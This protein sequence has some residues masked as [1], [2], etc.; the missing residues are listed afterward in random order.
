MLTDLVRYKLAC[1]N[2]FD[3]K[4]WLP[5]YDGFKNRSCP[6]QQSKISEHAPPLPAPG[7]THNRAPLLYGHI[8]F[9][10]YV[11]APAGTAANSICLGS[12]ICSLI[13]K[14]Q[15]KHQGLDPLIQTVLG[16]RFW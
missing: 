5:E 8:L 1:L 3:E 13:Q 15:P 4:I 11:Q 2:K 12:C 7:R 9:P 14:M 10:F 6:A 16:G